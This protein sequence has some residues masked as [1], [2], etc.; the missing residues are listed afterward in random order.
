MLKWNDKNQAN[1]FFKIF[2]SYLNIYLNEIENLL[3]KGFVLFNPFDRD[4]ENTSLTNYLLYG[5]DE[6][7]N[8]IELFHNVFFDYINDKRRSFIKSLIIKEDDI[9]MGV[10]YQI[11][12][13]DLGYQLLCLGKVNQAIGLI[14]GEIKNNSSKIASLI[15]FSFCKHLLI[16]KN[17]EDSIELSKKINDK[18]FISLFYFEIFKL[19]NSDHKHYFS[20]CLEVIELI[21]SNIEKSSLYLKI[22]KELL[23]LNQ[24]KLAEEIKDKIE[25]DAYVITSEVV[26]SYFF[27]NK[28]RPTDKFIKDL[29]TKQATIIYDYDSKL[30]E[31]MLNLEN[32]LS[33]VTRNGKIIIKTKLKEEEKNQDYFLKFFDD[34]NLDYMYSSNDEEGACEWRNQIII[35]HENNNVE[36]L[37][38]LL[39]SVSRKR[40]LTATDSENHWIIK[41]EIYIAIGNHERAYECLINYCPKVEYILK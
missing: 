17:I 7:F 5:E 26:K 40:F 29:K 6:G 23:Y 41:A 20:K 27:L 31:E 3:I 39:K 10:G 30:K 21:D 4:Y 14:Q 16:K 19:S 8:L 1:Y 18:Y 22:Y 34:C 25:I 36:N 38:S 37:K 35:E 15:Y 2:D 32:S 33:D 9:F 28:N 24:L 11:D 12:Y 13:F